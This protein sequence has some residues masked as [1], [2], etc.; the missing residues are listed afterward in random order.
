MLIPAREFAE[1]E[2]VWMT[3][4]TLPAA[5]R[6]GAPRGWW[7]EREIVWLLAVMAVIYLSR[8]TALPVCG[9]ESRWANGATEMIA[10]GDWI[11]PRQQ[12]EVFP[13][14]PPLGSWTMALTALSW[15]RMDAVAIRLPS[16]LAVLATTLLIYGY[17]R[18]FMSPLGAGRR[19]GV[20]QFWPGIATGPARRIGG[21]VYLPLGRSLAGVALGLCRPVASLADLGGRLCA[22]GAGGAR[23]RAASADL[24]A[25]RDRR[26]FIA[27]A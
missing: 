22:G 12:G 18:T 3:P 8:I 4:S 9:E 17:A 23:Q 20:R 11:V 10:S 2:P 1:S 14:R 7:Q 13:E 26:V 6:R 15:G 19:G 27:E 25:G 16:V 5:Q 21:A 24:S